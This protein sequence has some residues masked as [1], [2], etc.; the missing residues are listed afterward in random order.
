VEVRDEGFSEPGRGWTVGVT[1]TVAAIVALCVA[2]VVIAGEA[3]DPFWALYLIWPA[4]VLGVGWLAMLGY[5]GYRRYRMRRYVL[6]PVVAA[7]VTGAL[8]VTGLPA[9][10]NLWIS[11]GALKQAAADCTDS[12]AGQWIGG[13]HVDRVRAGAD[14]ACYFTTGGF[15]D[16]RGWVYAPGDAPTTPDGR[17]TL[18]RRSGDWQRFHER[19]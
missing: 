15:I 3:V 4:G 17:Y 13:L 6:A 11:G 10:A 14:G 7:L 18:G 12:G 16:S 1:A 8:V 9:T 5:G 2:A 19:F